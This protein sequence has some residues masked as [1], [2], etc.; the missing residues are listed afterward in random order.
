MILHPSTRGGVCKNATCNKPYEVGTP[1]L[2]S[3]DKKQQIGCANCEDQ[4]I[5]AHL[6]ELMSAASGTSSSPT[7]TSGP[8][9]SQ[10]P[11]VYPW[12]GKK[13]VWKEETYDN[14]R[15][16][17]C[18]SAV[19]KGDMVGKWGSKDGG[20]WEIIR[21]KN[22][23]DLTP[24]DRRQFEGRMTT[25]EATDNSKLGERAGTYVTAFTFIQTSADAGDRTRLDMA[26]RA[27]GSWQGLHAALSRLAISNSSLA[28]STDLSWLGAWDAAC[29]SGFLP[30]SGPAA[31]A[32]LVPYNKVIDF[33]LGYKAYH[34]M[35]HM[36]GVTV[37]EHVVWDCEQRLG[38]MARPYREALHRTRGSRTHATAILGR[39]EAET[40]AAAFLLYLG[41]LDDSVQVINDAYALLVAG[42]KPAL[43]RE[44]IA[45]LRAGLGR[46]DDAR[47]LACAIAY[48]LYLAQQTQ[49]AIDADEKAVRAERA[50]AQKEQRAP[51]QDYRFDVNDIAIV[52]AMLIPEHLGGWLGY[53]WYYLLDEGRPPL[54][55]KPPSAVWQPP[56]LGWTT[57]EKDRKTMRVWTTTPIGVFA[58]GR[59]KAAGDDRAAWC[60]LDML[61]VNK[62]AA[63]GQGAVVEPNGCLAA[64]EAKSPWATDLIAMV[65]KTID[66]E[67]FT[68][69]KIPISGKTQ[70]ILAID[71]AGNDVP[72]TIVEASEVGHL[73]QVAIDRLRPKPKLLEENE[74]GY[75][76]PEAGPE[77]VGTHTEE[78]EEVNW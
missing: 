68:H 4:A 55:S 21:C 26:D 36:D 48:R 31:M 75:D 64:A 54:F 20:N 16:T 38:L 39:L 33:R 49:A 45:V 51:K 11:K 23:T 76:L 74:P 61:E 58:V 32:Y 43:S 53:D 34:Q 62:R 37:T 52:R 25:S 71:S 67:L 56:E 24:A 63:R 47:D 40:N 30:G 2:L 57:Y 70:S 1:L 5:L 60:W 59:W 9:A 41:E 35:G 8:T 10:A 77:K 72:G 28:E 65:R 14:K 69:G 22:C 27:F 78:D 42:Q 7:N 15:C 12:A 17:S 19:A 50:L 29:A 46:G 18:H 13:P 6:R 3:D 44:V 73:A 66:R